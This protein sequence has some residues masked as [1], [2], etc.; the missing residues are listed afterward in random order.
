MAKG[1][2]LLREYAKSKGYDAKEFVS[3][4]DDWYN[5]D[6]LTFK[7]SEGKIHSILINYKEL[8]FWLIKE[9]K[10]NV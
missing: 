4:E 5:T 1:R 8:V 2:R 6:K 3:L 7:D 9:N 10:I